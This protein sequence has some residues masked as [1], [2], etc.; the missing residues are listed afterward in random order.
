M[1]FMKWPDFNPK[2]LLARK[3]QPG[4]TLLGL[5]LEGS[6]LCG[7]EIR[8]TNGSVEV[9]RAFTG[10]LS[11]DVLTAE[12]E[13]AGREI[14][15]VLDAEG[16]RERFCVVGLPTGWVIPL[17][18]KLPELS[19]TD[20]ASFLELEAERGFPA[21]VET[22]VVAQVRY[23]SPGGDA[24][25]TLLGVPRQHVA[26]V[27]AVLHAAQLRPVAFGLGLAALPRA[28]AEDV[29]ATLFVSGAGMDLKLACGSGIVSL[30]RMDSTA[31]PGA[32]AEEEPLDQLARDIRISLGQLPPDLR[33]ALRTLTVMGRGRVAD[34]LTAALRPR[35]AGLDVAVERA[36]EY[37]PADFS[38]KLAPGTLISPELSL[39]TQYLA[40]PKT[41]IDFLPPKVSKWQQLSAR[42]SSQKLVVGG[43]TAGAVAALVGVAFAVQQ[44]QLMYWRAKFNGIK[45]RVV[46]LEAFQAD[47][48]RLRPWFDDSVRSLAILRRLT[49][50]FPEDGTVSAK[51][52]SVREAAAGG[53]P[54]VSCTGTARSNQALIQTIDRLSTS[55]GVTDLARG[56]IRGGSPMQFTFN[57][58]WDEKG[59]R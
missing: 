56:P 15:K 32:D 33:D 50:A 54:T 38:V 22:L 53:A 14:R 42:Y 46:E 12:P 41:A 21:S 7:V 10:S 23:R 52:V 49:E 13:L 24:F 57:F 58:R 3:R 18:V 19:E 2:Q 40:G 5:S 36:R 47:I 6:T 25:A 20:L 59:A 8:R 9:R 37:T 34:E 31:H 48:K 51:T 28:G 43:V 44:V 27:E 30:R 16:A 11:L 35:L 45:E 55:R 26:R 1:T 29:T 39:A 17:N 4:A